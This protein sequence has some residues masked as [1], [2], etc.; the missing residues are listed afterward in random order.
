MI[1]GELEHQRRDEGLGDT[2]GREQRALGHGSMA[3]GV[4]FS[5]AA[6]PDTCARDHDGRG[7]AWQFLVLAHPLQRRLQPRGQVGV[8]P[9]RLGASR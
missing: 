2:A 6:G 1:L 9:A 3:A 7:R 8:E 5:H 4:G